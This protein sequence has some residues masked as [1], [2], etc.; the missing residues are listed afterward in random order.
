MPSAL[1]APGN[2]GAM[3]MSGEASVATLMERARS[4]DVARLFALFRQGLA[5]F[6]VDLRYPA[7]AVSFG[8]CVFVLL[9][10]ALAIAFTDPNAIRAHAPPPPT[11]VQIEQANKTALEFST[12]SPAERER[13]KRGQR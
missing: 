4:I 10:A 7:S 11:R 12:L 2:L 8:S 1:E 9:A 13:L 3:P 5:D 6:L